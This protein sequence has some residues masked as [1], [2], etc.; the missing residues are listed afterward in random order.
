M[1]VRKVVALAGLIAI[2]AVA[3]G[4]ATVYRINSSVQEQ[5]IVQP[6]EAEVSQNVQCGVNLG[7]VC[8]T[9][10]VV[11]SPTTILD[12]QVACLWVSLLLPFFQFL[13]RRP[14]DTSISKDDTLRNDR[15]SPVSSRGSDNLQSE[16]PE[17]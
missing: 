3:L 5:V 16:L 2:I 10:S 7:T 1:S 14:G 9:E 17:R 4:A 6:V 11:P 15:R 8:S 12:H 13:K